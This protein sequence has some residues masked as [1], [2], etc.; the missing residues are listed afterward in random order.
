MEVY[1]CMRG[2]MVARTHIRYNYNDQNAQSVVNAPPHIVCG[3]FVAFSSLAF[4]LLS[5]IHYLLY[6]CPL[7]LGRD[8]A[9]AK[10]GFAREMALFLNA[11]WPS[12]NRNAE[13]NGVAIRSSESSAWVAP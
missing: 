13:I 2:G 12:F 4:A 7:V 8:G 9:L 3:Q 1:K 6:I 10:D 5:P 11:N